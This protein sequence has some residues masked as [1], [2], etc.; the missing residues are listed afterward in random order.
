MT[1]Y[2]RARVPGSAYFFTAVTYRR[3]PVLTSTAHIER[4]RVAFRRVMHQQPF[5]IDAIVVLPDHVHTVWH[6]PQ[7]DTDYSTRW[8]VIKH[9]FSVGTDSGGDIA[10]SLSG[11]REKGIWQRRFW[12]HALRD[13]EDWRRHVDYV[14]FNAVRHGYV[15]RPADWPYG[16]FR[17]AVQRGWYTPDWGDT[18][19][20]NIRGMDLE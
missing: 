4:L 17:R 9:F 11:K 12:E 2:R 3:A 10:P 7:D 18:E 16:S 6:L 13:E 1:S 8:R 19:P 15:K 5:E 14:H 20:P